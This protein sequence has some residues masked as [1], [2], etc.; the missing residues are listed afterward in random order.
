MANCTKNSPK[1]LR[2]LVILPNPAPG[3][4]V[5]G[6]PTGVEVAQSSTFFSQ[7]RKKPP[8]IGGFSQLFSLRLAISVNS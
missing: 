3:T 8:E 1:K 2:G 5:E 7:K 6:R 4:Y